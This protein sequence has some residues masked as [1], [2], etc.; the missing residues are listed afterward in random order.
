MAQNNYCW[1]PRY[2]TGRLIKQKNVKFY[3]D[4]AKE[5]YI[6]KDNK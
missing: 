4:K 1:S 3:K 2:D 5:G 6:I